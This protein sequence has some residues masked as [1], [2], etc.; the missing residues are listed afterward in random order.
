MLIVKVFIFLTIL[1]CTFS[2]ENCMCQWFQQT[3]PVSGTINDIAFFDANTGLISMYNSSRILKTTNGGTNWYIAINYLKI[4]YLDIVDSQAVYGSGHTP[5][6]GNSEIYRSFDRGNTWDSVAISYN[7]SYAGIWF[8]NRDTGWI[9]GYDGNINRIYKTTDGGVSIFSLSTNTGYGQITFLKKPING[10]YYGWNITSGFLL[11]TTN[12][13]INWINISNPLSSGG[14]YWI[15][16]FNRDS[17]W[18]YINNYPS[19]IMFTSNGGLNWITKFIDT[20]NYYVGLHFANNNKGWS[21]GGFYKIYATTDGGT[22]W[23]TQNLPIS[24]GRPYDYSF[25]DSLIGWIGYSFIAKTTNGGGVITY[26]GI[27]SNY[28]MIPISF[29][30]KQNYPN[31][32]NPSTTIKFSINKSSNVNLAIYDLT[33]KEIIKVYENKFLNSGNY[34]VMLDFSTLNLPSGVYFYVLSITDEKQNQVFS[35]SRKMVYLR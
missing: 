28:T 19:R 5:G 15:D 12:S 16:F 11:R 7:N 31:P 1:H 29:I 32:F 35:Q 4:T 3:L 26:S 34:K 20:N 25:V 23:G 33:G 27:D 22:T 13:G 14:Y 30:I 10:E 9:S 24:D 2:I 8:A 6:N 21:G 17:G 18:S